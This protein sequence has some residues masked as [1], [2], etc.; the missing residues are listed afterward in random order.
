M[1]TNRV[2]GKNGTIPWDLPA[3]RE[4]FRLTTIGHPV[5][6]GR[7]TFESIGHPLVGRRTIVVTRQA[8]YA[9][10]GCCIAHS[11]Q[12]ALQQCSGEGEVFICGGEELYRQGLLLASRLYITQ[13]ELILE[14]DTRFP[15]F[16]H[17]DFR[18]VIRDPLPGSPAALFTVW[19]RI[20]PV[21]NY[22]SC[23]P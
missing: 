22:V 23:D 16:S 1:S 14:G 17:A 15:E 6:M 7:R 18:E 21:I 8:A 12:D 3:D 11:L 5:I 4:R 20:S 2:I 13:V 19:Q 10:D 9:A